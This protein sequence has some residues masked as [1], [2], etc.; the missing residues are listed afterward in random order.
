[1]RFN[2]EK[3]ADIAVSIE[4]QALAGASKFVAKY[5]FPQFSVTEAGGTISFAKVNKGTGSKNRENGK[6]LNGSYV[7]PVQISYTVAMY[8]DRAR[9]TDKDVAGYANDDAAIISGA[10]S[11]AYGVIAKVE[12]DAADTVFTTERYS[13][14]L[15]I[16]ADDPFGAMMN[17]ATAVKRFGTPT[18][19]CSESW[20][21]KFVAIEGVR[22]V[23]SD[24]YGHQI[25]RDVINAIPEAVKA[26][27]AVF[28]VQKIIIGDDSFWSVAEK[29]D[30]AA[31]IG[32]R[33]ELG[34][35]PRTMAKTFPAFGVA[36][37]LIP[38][39]GDLSH[40]LEVETGYDPSTKDNLVDCQLGT[41]ITV[42]NADGAVL[43]KLPA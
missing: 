31:V 1:M 3:R 4:A 7:S 16:T 5:I 2:S 32:I 27:G 40:P 11:A 33:E 13:A 18:L 14:A 43:V 6:A 38:D 26:C 22:K 25:I 24:L 30:A 29:T 8:E 9:L 36:P 12:K 15:A 39:G 42:I 41:A 23:L 10:M 21:A 37:T 28:G 17:A 35:D 34:N 19:V 20:L